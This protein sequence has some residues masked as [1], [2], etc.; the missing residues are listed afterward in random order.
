MFKS[1]TYLEIG[2]VDGLVTEIGSTYVLVGS[3]I[4]SLPSWVWF[5][6]VLV[7]IKLCE[8]VSFAKLYDN[9]KTYVSML[10]SF[11]SMSTLCCFSKCRFKLLLL[12]K[13]TWHSKHFNSFSSWKRIRDILK[14]CKVKQQDKHKNKIYSVLFFSLFLFLY[15]KKLISKLYKASRLIISGIEGSFLQVFLY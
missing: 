15:F 11:V 7:L 2:G 6:V 10:I 4:N 5:S 12:V 14:L 9:S 3:V 8:I 13:V 1:I